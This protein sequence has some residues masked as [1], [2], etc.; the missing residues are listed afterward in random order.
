MRIY[1]DDVSRGQV[2]QKYATRRVLIEPNSALATLLEQS[3]QWNEIYQDEMAIL[4]E[5]VEL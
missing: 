1:R 3:S 4:L 5:R 2:F